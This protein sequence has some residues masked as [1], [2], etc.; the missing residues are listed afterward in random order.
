MQ[1]NPPKLPSEGVFI[2][3]LVYFAYSIM[4]QAEVNYE[5]EVY[6]ALFE[7]AT[8]G[9]I[10]AD[11]HGKI[12]MANPRIQEL[13]GYDLSEMIGSEVEILLPKKIHTV[14]KTYRKGYFDAPV[15]RSMGSGRDLYARR[16]DGSEFPV[17]VSL[18]HFQ[19]KG[20]TL[21]MALITDISLRKKAESELEAL[22]MGLEAQVRLQTREIRE[23]QR[24]FSLIARNFPGGSINVFD[25]DLNYVYV[26]GKELYRMG[27]TSD[28]LTGTSYLD[29]LDPELR[30]TMQERLLPVFEGKNA[31][32]EISHKSNEYELSA[33]G[34]PDDDGAIN[35]ILVVEHNI[36]RQKEEQEEVK[37]ALEKERELNELKSRFV[38]M[39]SHE[40]RTPLSTILTSA[41]LVSR[42]DQPDHAP[43]REKHLSRIRNS[44]RNL[45][46]ILDDFLSLDKLET[47]NIYSHPEP[48]ELPPLIE[49]LV[50]EMEVLLQ[51]DQQLE[52][53]HE[54]ESNSTLDPRLIRNVLINLVSNAMK[55]STFGATIFLR[56][57]HDGNEIR[58]EVEDQG[59]G[60]PEEEQQY[61]FERFFRATNVINI[62]GTG[63]GLNIVQKYLRLMDGE[64][65]FESESGKGTTFFIRLPAHIPTP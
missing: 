11:A 5:L 19:L 20:E 3:V 33:V 49:G 12:L 7:S 41:S 38:S 62:Q 52:Y 57:F 51:E 31:V 43:K 22:N 15:R 13:F 56:S 39:A 64:I 27:V 25:R 55:Y 28:K 6:R 32:F 10:V 30:D 58:L 16:K 42:Y 8:E 47:G 40:F 36:S 50:E 63:L 17:E 35:Q 26:E 59:I 23:S 34:L 2:L 46:S 9:L 45:T 61:I 65:Y 4:T 18:N 44:V 1:V 21:A 29:H 60:I 48:F 54:G 14:H 37:R 53:V 24:L